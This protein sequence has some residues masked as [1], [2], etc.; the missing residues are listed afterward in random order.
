MAIAQRAGDQRG[1]GHVV[2]RVRVAGDLVAPAPLAA[3]SCPN[4]REGV[5]LWYSKGHRPGAFLLCLASLLLFLQRV[6]SR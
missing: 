5:V 1:R 4:I 6:S 2:G 3:F